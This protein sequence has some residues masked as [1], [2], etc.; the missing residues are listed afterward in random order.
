M[1]SSDTIGNFRNSSSKKYVK[2]TKNF[3]K[4]KIDKF[5]RATLTDKARV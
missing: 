1:G 4:Q 3:Q 2:G 5:A